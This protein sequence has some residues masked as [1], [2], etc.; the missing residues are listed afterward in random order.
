MELLLLFGPETRKRLFIQ[1]DWNKPY[2]RSVDVHHS[3][4]Q[5]VCTVWTLGITSLLLWIQFHLT[6]RAW[7]KH[8]TLSPRYR[9]SSPTQCGMSPHSL[10]HIHQEVKIQVIVRNRVLTEEVVVVEKQFDHSCHG[11]CTDSVCTCS[12]AQ[13]LQL[14]CL[15]ARLKRHSENEEGTVACWR[16]TVWKLKWPTH[17]DFS[18]CLGK[19]TYGQD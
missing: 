8:T 2:G 10:R 1:K 11:P 9:G 13:S 15:S 18:W 14:L 3:V 19:R 12:A 7:H 17:T 4:V 6:V 5:V 16:S